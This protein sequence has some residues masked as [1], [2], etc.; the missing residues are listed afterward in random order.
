MEEK[1]GR[2]LT[3][4]ETVHH[5]YGIKDDNN[6]D[7]LELWSGSHPAGCRVNDLV[8]FSTATLKKYAPELLRH[9]PMS[10]LYTNYLS[11]GP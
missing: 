7:H 2:F 6:P 10:C 3:D 5:K 11:L 9:I 8:E 4:K 1:L